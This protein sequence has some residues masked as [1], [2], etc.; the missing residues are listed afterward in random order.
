MSGRRQE[1]LDCLLLWELVW[2][3]GKAVVQSWPGGQGSWRLI[4]TGEDSVPEGLTWKI[5]VAGHRFQHES[6]ANS[7]ISL[8]LKQKDF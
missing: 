7:Y 8:G 6:R 1:N 3:P 5:G 2:M 4:F